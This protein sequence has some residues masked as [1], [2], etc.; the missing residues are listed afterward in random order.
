M[1]D[2]QD[3]RFEENEEVVNAHDVSEFD[4]VII[5][6]YLFY[7]WNRSWTCWFHYT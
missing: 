2:N 1:A 7:Y 5:G 6:I 4:Q 3:N